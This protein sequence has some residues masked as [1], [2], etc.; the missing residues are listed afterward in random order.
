MI[1][2]AAFISDYITHIEN[3]SSVSDSSSSL[4]SEASE[5]ELDEAHVFTWKLQERLAKGMERSEAEM[6][7][8]VAMIH[9]YLLYQYAVQNEYL[10]EHGNL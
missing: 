7:A 9:E 5:E 1:Q 10:E 6:S 4:E 3:G 8:R 2:D